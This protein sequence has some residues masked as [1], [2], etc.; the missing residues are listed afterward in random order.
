MGWEQRSLIRK[1][2]LA[3][4]ISMHCAKHPQSIL[5]HA[6]P[7]TW[8]FTL[9]F[10]DELDEL[11]QDDLHELGQE[12]R[13]IDEE[14][15]SVVPK[16]WILK[17]ALADRGNGIR[18]FSTR[19][20]LEEIFEEFEVE[21]SD[22][23]DDV[24]DTKYGQGKNTAV[25]SSQMREWIVQEYISKPLLLDPSPL[26][27]SLGRKFHLRGKCCTVVNLLD[28]DLDDCN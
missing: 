15:G 24:E 7:R 28:C 19:Q 27:F 8:S 26:G 11:L 5:V 1:N 25:D 4:T 13:L 18:L 12:F 14:G 22:D 23:E 2:H 10:S 17:A 21:D 6:I 3:H 16:W 20:E 9:A